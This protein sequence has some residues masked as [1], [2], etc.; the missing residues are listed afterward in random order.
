MWCET[1]V[2]WTYS[3]GCTLLARYYINNNVQ[4]ETKLALFFAC[5]VVIKLLNNFSY[6]HFP[7]RKYRCMLWRCLWQCHESQINFF[8]HVECGLLNASNHISTSPSKSIH[9]NIK[10]YAFHL[11]RRIPVLSS[12]ASRKFGRQILIELFRTTH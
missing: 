1:L 3:Y 6:Y 12:V 9:F 10:E 8:I 2:V 7:I 5:V 11:Y 4:N